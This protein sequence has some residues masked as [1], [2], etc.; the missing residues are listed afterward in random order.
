MINSIIIAV[1]IIYLK[2]CCP[3]CEPSKQQFD[4]SKYQISIDTFGRHYVDDTGFW[5]SSARTYVIGKEG[6][7]I[8]KKIV[9]EGGINGW[10]VEGVFTCEERPIVGNTY[11]FWNDT[12]R[13]DN[14]TIIID[15]Q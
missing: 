4:L 13:Y 9:D 2:G 12:T 14:C 7:D 6:E 3:E 5:E 11:E 15:P 10:W 1:S 8:L